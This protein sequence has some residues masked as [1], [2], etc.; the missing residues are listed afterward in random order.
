M[1]YSMH[2]KNLVILQRSDNYA[3][4]KNPKIFRREYL[5]CLSFYRETKKVEFCFCHCEHYYCAK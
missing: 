4:L 3:P 2:C 1:L 5:S